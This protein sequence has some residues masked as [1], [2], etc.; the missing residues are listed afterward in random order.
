[1]GFSRPGYWSGLTFPSP[2]DL[3]DPEI[4]PMSPTLQGRFFTLWA[5]REA[6]SS[7][8][9][10]N[11]YITFLFIWRNSTSL[12]RVIEGQRE[13][14]NPKIIYCCHCYSFQWWLPGYYDFPK[15]FLYQ[16]TCFSLWFFL[17]INVY[18]KL[19][20]NQ[21]FHK[22]NHKRPKDYDA[23]VGRTTEGFE[24]FEASFS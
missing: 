23:G 6:S 11:R 24:W 8:I 21:I 22:I 20:Y 13:K 10:T 2:G 3:L 7:Y 15:I 4:K 9:D 12:K 5:I 16:Y 14:E 17:S 19:S 18:I 1:M